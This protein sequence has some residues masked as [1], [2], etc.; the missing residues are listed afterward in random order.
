MQTINQIDWTNE[1]MIQKINDFLNLYQHRP[2][3]DNTGGGLS[4]NMFYLWYTLVQTKPKYIIESGIYRGQGTWLIE[5]ILP[6][7]KIV[8]IDPNLGQRTYVS[9][10]AKYITNDFLELTNNSLSR[11]ICRQTFIY[12]DDH[13]DQYKR[14]LHAQ[15]L[16]FIHILLDDNYPTYCGRRHISI[17]ACLNQSSDTQNGYQLPENSQKILKDI[18]QRYFMFP[19]IFQIN[20]PVS[21]EKSIVTIPPLISTVSSK[22]QIFQNDIHNYRW[23]TYIELNG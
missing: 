5:N 7:S 1:D 22:Y 11:D 23:S 6:D 20:E 10:K 13:Q 19:P 3:T 9:K 16:G 2:I 12:F 18:I 17:E 15:K 21:M 8:S 4:V 14:L